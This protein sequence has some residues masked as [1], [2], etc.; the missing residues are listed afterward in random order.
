MIRY[1]AKVEIGHFEIRLIESPWEYVTIYGVET[2]QF[3]KNDFS[4]AYKSFTSSV[5]HAMEFCHDK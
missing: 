3:K 4:G 5:K 2:K 1:L